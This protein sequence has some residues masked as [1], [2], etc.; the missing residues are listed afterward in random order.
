MATETPQGARHNKQ[1][2]DLCEKVQAL[3]D[4]LESHS[5]TIEALEKTISEQTAELK[6]VAGYVHAHHTT[7]TEAP[8]NG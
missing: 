3:E 6:R 7:P 2:Y 1:W 8:D 4:D 5:L